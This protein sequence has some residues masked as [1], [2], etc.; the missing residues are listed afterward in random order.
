MRIFIPK[1]IE[2][3]I[4]FAIYRLTIQGF[5]PGFPNLQVPVNSLVSEVRVKK[6]I[7]LTYRNR[8]VLSRLVAA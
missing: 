2:I 8:N 1:Q 4:A 7:Y 5:F 3:A 6:K